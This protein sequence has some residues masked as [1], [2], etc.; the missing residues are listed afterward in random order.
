[1]GFLEMERGQLS[2]SS[3]GADNN[4]TVVG[5]DRQR[6]GCVLAETKIGREGVGGV[7]DKCSGM[8]LVL[9]RP[10]TS[11]VRSVHEDGQTLT[12]DKVLGRPETS[13]VRSVHED[14]QTLTI[15]KVLGRPETSLVRPV[16]E[17]GQL[18][19]T[20]KRA[21]RPNVQ[22]LLC[23]LTASRKATLEEITDASVLLHLVDISHP[24]AAAQ[25]DAVLQLGKQ[26]G[27][28]CGFWEYE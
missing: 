19:T 2:L 11:L 7:E 8:K 12:I 6:T 18:L 13:L 15:D 21:I 28:L 1:M 27:A 22:G 26:V 23:C 24:N 4:D 17:D 16:H 5:K 25:C 3:H 20:G 9:G 10:E 14:G